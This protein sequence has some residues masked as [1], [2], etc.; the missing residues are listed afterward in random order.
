MILMSIKTF[1]TLLTVCVYVIYHRRVVA[2][3]NQ[4]TLIE[5]LIT[6]IICISL[7]I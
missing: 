5:R 4:A 2:A 3:G 7:F 6:I 1:F